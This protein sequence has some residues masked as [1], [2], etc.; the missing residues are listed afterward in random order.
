[1]ADNHDRRDFLKLVT[2]GAAL[3]SH[4]TLIEAQ[5]KDD[6]CKKVA[7]NDRVGIATIGLGG[8]GTSDTN[9]A[10]AV[11]GVELVAV[12]D[13]YD[14]RL[15]RA[16]EVYC[17]DVFTTRDYREVLA[18]KDVD[19]VI[20]GTPDHWHAQIAI[21]AMNAGKDVY[22]EKPMVRTPEE[23][24]RVIETQKKTGRLMQVG[25]QRTSSIV[26]KKAQELIQA[27]VIGELNAVEAVWNRNSSLGAWQYTIAPDA[28]PENVDWDRFIGSAPKRPFEPIRLFRWRNYQDYGTGVAGDL[29]VHLFSGMH[30]ITGAIGP[31]RIQATGGLRYWKDGRDVPDVMFGLYDY[32]KTATLPEFTLFLRVNF[33]DGSGGEE[34][35]RFV[36]PEGILSLAGDGITLNRPQREREPGYTV[37]T[38]PQGL[39]DSFVKEYRGKYPDRSREVNNSKVERFYAPREYS[40][41]R[42]HW[43]NFIESVRTRKPPFQDPIFG[44]RAAG[45]AVLS[46]LS[47]FEKRAVAWDPETMTIPGAKAPLT[48]AGKKK[49]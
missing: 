44:L 22:C 15:Q 45:P 48:T 5:E 8:M 2:A 16:R 43:R 46:N 18:R 7:A 30:F 36:G 33:A 24:Q 3:A 11:G 13:V 26:Y 34:S 12:A 23:G 31:T 39:Q 28:S 29:F 49:G 6:K 14:G 40:D 27:G 17:K 4:A 25:S 10:L 21:D 20:I 42:D 41:H 32:P 9:S 19:A 37:N 47:Y 1:M 38:F 35:F